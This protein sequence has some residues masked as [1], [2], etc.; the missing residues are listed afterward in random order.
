MGTAAHLN[1]SFLTQT[2]GAPVVQGQLG[3]DAVSGSP[4]NNDDDDDD[5]DK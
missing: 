4:S 2:V 1:M 3:A 5:N